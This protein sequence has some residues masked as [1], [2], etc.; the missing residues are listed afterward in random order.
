MTNTPHA[1]LVSVVIPTYRGDRFI[2]TALAH[3]AA[4]TWPDWEV[5]VINNFSSDN[6]IEVVES[7]HDSR[8]KIIIAILIFRTGWWIQC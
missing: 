4:Q 1:N 2:G 5:I 7:F 3:L 6:T 8:I